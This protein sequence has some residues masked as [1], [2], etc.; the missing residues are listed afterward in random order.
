MQD[1]CVSSVVAE[2]TDDSSLLFVRDGLDLHT[3]CEV[4]VPIWILR[5]TAGFD[6]YSLE[7]VLSFS[8]KKNDNNDKYLMREM[9]MGMLPVLM[10]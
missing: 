4:K 2:N 5:A 6:S 1:E 8:K 10:H 9:G 7:F 3:H